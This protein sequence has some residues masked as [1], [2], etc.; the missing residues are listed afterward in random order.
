MYASGKGTRQLSNKCQGSVRGSKRC[1]CCLLGSPVH[2]LEFS[3]SML[4]MVFKTAVIAPL[5]PLCGLFIGLVGI[6]ALTFRA[7]GSRKES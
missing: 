1:P 5:L 3:A 6:I 2:V 7:R 4:A